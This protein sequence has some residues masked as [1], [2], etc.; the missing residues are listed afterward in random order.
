M[1]TADSASTSGFVDGVVDSEACGGDGFSM[2]RIGSLPIGCIALSSGG[3]IPCG[4]RWKVW[5]E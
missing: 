4:E 2:L 5:I 1:M 3:A